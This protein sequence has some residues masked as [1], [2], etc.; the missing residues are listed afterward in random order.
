MNSTNWA[1]TPNSTPVLPYW[2]NDLLIDCHL[3]T[4]PALM[5]HRGYKQAA[6][7]RGW[8]AGDQGLQLPRHA[9]WI[10]PYGNRE[11]PRGTT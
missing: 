10:V 11:S 9:Q 2:R 3:I 8:T 4:K 1:Q 6:A 5:V 7:R